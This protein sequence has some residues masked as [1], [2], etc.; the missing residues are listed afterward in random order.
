MVFLHAVTHKRQNLTATREE[1][2]ID[3]WK[4]ITVFRLFSKK[5]NTQFSRKTKTY[6]SG[7]PLLCLYA[8]INEQ[9]TQAAVGHCRADTN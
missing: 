6:T 5:A 3:L 8:V 4:L 1:N 2:R 9:F 7:L